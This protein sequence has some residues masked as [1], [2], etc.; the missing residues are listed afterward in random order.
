MLPKCQRIIGA[1]STRPEEPGEVPP[2]PGCGPASDMGPTRARAGGVPVT[3]SRY[4]GEVEILLGAFEA[5][6]VARTCCVAALAICGLSGC[7]AVNTSTAPIAAMKAELTADQIDAWR[8]M[9]GKWFGSHP[10]RQGGR[11]AWL[12]SRSAD[13]T[14][15][16]TFRLRER[17]GRY[18]EQSQSGE[19]G[20][21]GSVYFTITKGIMED[22]E[23]T[24]VDARDPYY[25]DAYRIISLNES[26]F[27]Y[28]N[29]VTGNEFTVVRVA[30]GFRLP[31]I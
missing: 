30:D 22:G 13:G 15:H 4:N 18:V 11:R 9:V 31:A 28:R 1:R 21:A 25:R 19:W 5:R 2:V 20:I 10:T 24:A 6:R 8:L 17:D 14:Y 27:T 26:V 12:I 23:W 3:M 7:A 29:H 16:V